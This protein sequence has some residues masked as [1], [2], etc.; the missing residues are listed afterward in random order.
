MRTGRPSDY[1]VE[2][3]DKICRLLAE[4]QSLLHICNQGWTPNVATI[5]V[6]LRKHKD[7]ADKYVLARQQ[8]A[9]TLADRAVAMALHGERVIGDPQ[10]AKLQLDALK[11]AA[12]RLAPKVYGRKADLNLGGQPGNPVATVVRWEP[13]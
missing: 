10:S 7:F 1:S 5:Y 12:G 4:G 2:M 3:T 9:H 8:Q 6:W 13:S 11:W